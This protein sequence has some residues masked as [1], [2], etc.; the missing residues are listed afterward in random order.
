MF[1]LISFRNEGAFW[2]FADRSHLDQRPSSLIGGIL[3]APRRTMIAIGREFAARRAMRALS[4]LD[5]RMLRDIGLERDQIGS[6]ARQGR[7]TRAHDARADIVR[8]S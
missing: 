7:L 4:S 6:A 1:K 8:W 5:E 2:P 3:A